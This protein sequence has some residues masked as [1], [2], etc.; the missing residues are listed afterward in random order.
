MKHHE[1]VIIRSDDIG[2][3]CGDVCV[4]G[5]DVNDRAEVIRCDDIGDRCRDVI[6]QCGDVVAWRGDVGDNIIVLSR[7][8][9]GD[10]GAEFPAISAIAE[11]V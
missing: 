2:T 3:R 8:V 10:I 11:L 1:T 5:S 7:G 4:W 9:T 6:A